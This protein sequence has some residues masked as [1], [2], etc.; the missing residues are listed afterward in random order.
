[1][2][3]IKYTPR[4]ILAAIALAVDLPVPTDIRFG[5]DTVYLHFDRVG[6][7]VAWAKAMGATAEPYVNTDGR[8]YVGAGMGSWHG[9]KVSIH[10]VDPVDA[11][12]AAEQA[13]LTEIVDDGE[14]GTSPEVAR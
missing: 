8:R 10:A 14:P 7:G 5:P 11:L 6:D 4:Q 12:G 2:N 9:W 3:P 13:A 1:M